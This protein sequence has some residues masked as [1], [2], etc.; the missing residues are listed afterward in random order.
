M[1]TWKLNDDKLADRFRSRTGVGRLILYAGLA[2]VCILGSTRRSAAQL[3]AEVLQQ[4]A[5]QDGN[6]YQ[7]SVVTEKP[8]GSVL[9]LSIDSAIQLGLQHNLGII[10]QNSNVQSAAGQRLQDL[11]ALLPDVTANV[12]ESVTQLNLRAEGLNFP[13]FPSIIGPFGVTDLR[14]Y[15][16]QAL[17]NVK[18]LDTFLASKHNFEA[19]KLSAEDARDLVVLTVGN[20]YLTTLAD[21]A[22]IESVKSQLDTSKVSLDEAVANHDAGV[23]PRLDLLRAQVDYQS[24]Q[25]NLIASRNQF[26]KDK[27][28]LARA[29]GLPLEQVYTLS[30]QAP[31]AQL[32]TVDVDAAVLQAQQNRKDLQSLQQQVKAAE[33]QS[34][35]ATAE[36]F[37]T[38]KFEGDYGDIGVNPNSSHGT[39]SATGSA[40]VPIFEEGKLRGDKRVAD[41]ALQQKQAQLND[42]RMQISADVRDSVLDIQAAAKLVDVTRSNADL[43]REAVSEAQQ[44]FKAGVSDNLSVSQAQ[45]QLEQAN[46][47]YISALYQHNMAKLTLA[48]AL[49]VAQTHYKDYVGG[50]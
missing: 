43:A 40:S 30:D 5:S 11:Q 50:K 44:R 46:D 31:F 18:S 28:A 6:S 8:T 15:L 13:G 16:T 45:S 36:R 7:G 19:A 37:P 32:D 49:G 48:R 24:Q 4:P 42:M 10:L 25:Q 17:V 3:P 9:A 20:A 22:R 23:S 33:L 21:A 35:A 47:Q 14:V 26:E 12:R 2:A 34:K 29:I 41:A 38:A 1:T 39:G 27:I